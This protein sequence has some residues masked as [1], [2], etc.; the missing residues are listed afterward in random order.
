M[1]YL[2]WRD[3][4]DQQRSDTMQTPRET[5]VRTQTADE[6]GTEPAAQATGMP[7][8]G[9]GFNVRDL[10]LSLGVNGALPFFTYQFLQGRGVGELPALIISG[11]FPA[12]ATVVSVARARR[13]DILGGIALL[14]IAVG[15]LAALIGGDPKLVLIRESFVTAALGLAALVSLATPRPMLFLISRQM[16]AGNDP[17]RIAYMERAMTIP[18]WRRFFRILTLMWGGVWIGEFILKIV[19][20]YSLSIAQVL[21]VG[22]LVFNTITFG[23]IALT[24][25]YVRRARSASRAAITVTDAR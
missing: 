12:I 6:L 22:P 19:L 14:G 5:P 15:V 25:L 8:A 20:V 1:R 4:K 23:L 9:A 2:L 10:V 13:V 21:V 7:Q 17:T 11:V 3:R 16:T 18:R 24:V